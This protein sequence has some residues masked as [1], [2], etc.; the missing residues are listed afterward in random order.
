MAPLPGLWTP[1]GPTT[2]TC[3]PTAGPWDEDARENRGPFDDSEEALAVA[4][5]HGF[6]TRGMPFSVLW[7]FERSFYRDL[8]WET[9]SL[10]GEVECPPA[11]VRGAGAAPTGEFVPV[12]PKGRETLAPILDAQEAE[13]GLHVDRSA[14]WWEKRV[15]QWWGGEDSFGYRWDDESGEPRASLVYRFAEGDGDAG[16]TLRVLET[17]WTDLEAYHHLLRFL[18]DHDSQAET[19]EW[20]C[21]HGPEATLL[22]L[23]DDPSEIAVRTKAGPMVRIGDVALALSALDYPADVSESVTLA[24]SDPFLPDNDGTFRLEVEGGTV[25]CGPTTVD[26]DASLPIEALSQLSVGFR[27]STFLAETGTLS[28]DEGTV[29]SLDTLFPAEPTLLREGF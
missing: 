29:T 13:R 24:V 16:R 9:C 4:G 25:R 18:G 10:Y 26:T 23:V 12:G 1:T 19:V 6:R 14:E 27:D 17:A 11:Q 15:F 20:Y 3:R 21:P 22:T 7:P 5:F 2:G 8:G 28:A